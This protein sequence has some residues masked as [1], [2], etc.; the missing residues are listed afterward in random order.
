[1]KIKSLCLICALVCA[2]TIISVGCGNKTGHSENSITGTW[3]TKSPAFIDTKKYTDD[4]TDYYYTFEEGGKASVTT[5][6]FSIVGKWYY[7]D[8]SG[9]KIDSL[10][11]KVKIDVQ[12]MIS[13][14]YSAEVKIL[15]KDKYTLKLTDGSGTSMTLNS[16]ELPEIENKIP[17]DFK[18][19]DYITGRWHAF[20][21]E[22]DVYLFN[23]DGTCEIIQASL[24]IKGT[25]KVDEKNR[26]IKLTYLDHN[27]QN[28]WNIPY[29]V[30][31]NEK[32]Q[33]ITF[34]NSVF[35]KE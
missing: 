27:Q 14:T 10:R 33:K 24:E 28:S 3:V 18:E 9:K 20:D 8:N 12:T 22:K 16:S 4:K 5:G 6:T 26:I 25:Y 31:E 32:G 2:I 17:D 7:V 34:S 13:G 21:D 15:S 23:S 1:M 29:I 11:N 30:K 19:V 35:I